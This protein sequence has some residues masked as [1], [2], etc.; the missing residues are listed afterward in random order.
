VTRLYFIGFRGDTRTP[1]KE[2]NSKLEIPA[3]NAADA[4]LTDRLQEKASGQQTTAR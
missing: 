1:R 4:S 3:A 2:A